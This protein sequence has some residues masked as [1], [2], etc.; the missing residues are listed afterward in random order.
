MDAVRVKPVVLMGCPIYEMLRG[1][2]ESVDIMTTT[3]PND[4]VAV[5][6]KPRSTWTAKARIKGLIKPTFVVVEQAYNPDTEWPMLKTWLAQHGNLLITDRLSYVRGRGVFVH[7]HGMYGLR[8]QLCSSDTV[9]IIAWR[10]DLP[11]LA[12]Y[13]HITAPEGCRW[14]GLMPLPSVGDRVQLHEFGEGSVVDYAID[15][16]HNIFPRVKLLDPFD[17]QFNEHDP[18]RII[19]PEEI[20]S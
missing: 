6:G 13:E 14:N 4:I 18:C 7:H 16:N 15:N 11:G 17:Y 3:C 9:A 8:M 1:G 5:Y 19:T 12:S 2:F 20:R 10:H